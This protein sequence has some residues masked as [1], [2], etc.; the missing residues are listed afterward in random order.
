MSCICNRCFERDLIAGLGVS[1]SGLLANGSSSF[2]HRERMLALGTGLSQRALL[3]K[4]SRAS[5]PNATAVIGEHR[6]VP[7]TTA[8]ASPGSALWSGRKS[9]SFTKEFMGFWTSVTLLTSDDAIFS[10]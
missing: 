4:R 7:G 1:F 3:V 9:G 10:V 6:S 5:P 8:F 2:Q